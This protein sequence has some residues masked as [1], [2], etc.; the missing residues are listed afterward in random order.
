MSTPSA[1]TGGVHY[2]KYICK[3][4]WN[5]DL[6]DHNNNIVDNFGVEVA[7]LLNGSNGF[8]L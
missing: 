7:Y 8:L 3:D 2:S 5:I 1:V 4:G 6:K